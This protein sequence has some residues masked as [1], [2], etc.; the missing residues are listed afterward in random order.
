M[1]RK[2]VIVGG[3]L[4]GLA[5]GLRLHESGIPFLLLEAA[6]EVGG[7]ARTDTVDGFQL[8]RGFQVLLTSYPEAQRILDYETLGLARFA[9]GALIR[10][11]GKFRRFVDPWRSPRHFLTTAFSPIGS[12]ADKLR[13]SR[14]RSRVTR[15]S[16]ESLFSRPEITTS[17]AL[18]KDRFSAAMTERFFRPFLGGVFLEPELATSSRMF[19]FVFRMFATGDAALPASGM[20]ALA[21]QI[22]HKLP[23]DWIRLNAKVAAIEDNAVRLTSGE[24]LT[25]DRIVV[26]CDAHAAA[27]LL[28]TPP[29]P[30]GRSVTCL[31]FTA[32]A[33]PAEEP[34]LVLNG[35]GCGPINNLCVPSQVNSSYAPAGKSLVSVTVLG[36]HGP[37]MEGEVRQQLNDWYGN[38]VDAWRHLQT[39]RISNAFPDQ[40][41]PALTPVEKTPRAINGVL[42]CGDY[43][44]T[45]SIQGAMISGRRAA[46]AILE[47]ESQTSAPDSR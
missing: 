46:E 24:V 16:L 31:Y 18:R 28:G 4:A 20:G 36:Q 41:P 30:P 5:C 27:R 47:D 7:R 40:T 32:S 45:A 23:A 6:S 43:L 3:G 38:Q 1:R 44:D 2:V 13:M 39:Y 21:G 34:I 9:P 42:C 35:D 14:L 29:P 25:A 37:E 26:A 33:P 10:Y 22:A 19:E 12:L 8:D 15:G 11:R 17:Q